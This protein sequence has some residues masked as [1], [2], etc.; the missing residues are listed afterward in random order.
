[1]CTRLG[2]DGALGLELANELF[3]TEDLA[4]GATIT[5]N[6]DV[7]TKRKPVAE[8]LNDSNLSSR[9]MNRIR[10]KSRLL[11]KQRTEEEPPVKKIKTEEKVNTASGVQQILILPELLTNKVWDQKA[12][13]RIF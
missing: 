4:A 9:E 5:T 7:Q 11:T 3:T 13:P 6:G 10:R 8:T 12:D 2:L 1:M